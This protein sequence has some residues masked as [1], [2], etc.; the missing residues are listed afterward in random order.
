MFKNLVSVLVISV[1]V[2]K[3]SK[4]NNIILKRVLYIYYLLCFQKDILEIEA[5]VTG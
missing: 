2:I 3:A 4:K 1:L 5:F